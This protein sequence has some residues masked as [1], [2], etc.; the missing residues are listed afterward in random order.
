MKLF[1]AIAAG[2]PVAFEVIIG[3]LF[4]VVGAPVPFVELIVV[5]GSACTPV[6]SVITAIKHRVI[7]IFGHLE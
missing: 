3:M 7:A 4:V 2:E 1:T 6:I 5:Q